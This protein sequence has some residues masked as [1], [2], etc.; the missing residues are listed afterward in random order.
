MKQI[1]LSRKYLI[2]MLATFLKLVRVDT[3]STE[4][5]PE[6]DEAKAADEKQREFAQMLVRIIRDLGH[7][8]RVTVHNYVHV[9]LPSNLPE[10]H[11]AYGRVPVINYLAHMDTY[12]G[13][14]S[15]NIQPQVIESYDGKSEITLPGSGA[16]LTVS[17]FPKLAECHGHTLVTSDG[18]T[19][20]GADDKAGIALLFTILKWL[21]DHPEFL[22]GPL[23]VVITTNEEVGRGTEYFT[24]H[25][26]GVD[27]LQARQ[28]YTWDG[29]GLGEVEDETFCAD[30]GLVTIKGMDCHPG[31]AKGKMVNAVEIAGALLEA[32][33]QDKKPRTT[34]KRQPYIHAYDMKGDVNKV[35]IKF[36]F[37]AFTVEELLEMERILKEIA[38]EVQTRFSGSEIVVEV[39]EQ[40]RN[41]KF[42]IDKD[43]RVVEYAFEACR[44]QGIKPKCK[45]IRGGTDGARLSYMGMLTPNVWAGGQEFHSVNE[46]MSVQWMAMAAETGIQ[47]LGVWV[48]KSF[49]ADDGGMGAAISDN[50]G[51]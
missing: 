25:E 30:G 10:G 5:D 38:D 28:A 51:I 36:L 34:E 37:R 2:W 33:P 22:H 48:E 24:A 9:Y 40:Y 44:R 31:E 3:R 18:N 46:W 11:L 32:L 26:L 4:A 1:R 19:L 49:P 47:L 21:K 27:V 50:R 42:M 14:E 35:E 7:N 16:K 17:E 20:L 13:T 43:P 41:M 6:T 8:A 29:S 15:A 45:E 39:K 23:N 12:H